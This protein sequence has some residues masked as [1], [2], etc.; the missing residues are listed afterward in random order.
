MY[1][2][3][4]AA[5]DCGGHTF[6]AKGRRILSE[7]WREIDHIFRA[8]LKEQPE[9][10]R[11]P[12]LCRTSPRGNFLTRWRPLSPKHFTAPPKAYTED[13][14]LAA[15]ETA[16]KGTGGRRAQGLGTPATRA[17]I[18]EKLVA[19][20]FVER[21]G[22]SLIPTPKRDQPGHC[23]AGYFDLSHAHGGSGDRS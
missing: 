23:P 20:G 18:L 15:M 16:G 17:A 14:L 22:K 13:T 11:N 10:R 8:S 2:A 7:G 3:A 4:T 9:A 19:A 5:F 1:E 6:T 12:P 21:K